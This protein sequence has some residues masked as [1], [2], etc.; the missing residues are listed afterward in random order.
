MWA[1]P[2][3]CIASAS[4]SPLKRLL[5]A[6]LRTMMRVLYGLLLAVPETKYSLASYLKLAKPLPGGSDVAESNMVPGAVTS[7]DMVGRDT[8]VGL[9]GRLGSAGACPPPR[10]PAPPR[11]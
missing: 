9:S 5:S 7:A 2:L 8:A 3:G 1:A 4:T 10:W 6:G 11:C